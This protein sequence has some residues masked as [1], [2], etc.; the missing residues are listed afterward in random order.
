MDGEFQGSHS[1]P[2]ETFES[3]VRAE[4]TPKTTYLNTAS[5][6]LLPARTVAA[7]HQ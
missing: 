5:N 7:L 2:M 6:G 3:L 4:F 1:G